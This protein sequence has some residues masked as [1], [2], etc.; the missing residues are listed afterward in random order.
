VT[1]TL[2]DDNI[3]NIAESFSASVK[4][5]VNTIDISKKELVQELKQ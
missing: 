1:K 3:L 2:L 5:L 4:E